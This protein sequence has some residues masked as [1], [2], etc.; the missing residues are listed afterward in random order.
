MVF[1]FFLKFLPSASSTLEFSTFEETLL[2]L[3]KNL[4][5]L[6]CDEFS[7]D[8]LASFRL[9]ILGACL[10]YSMQPSAFIF[11]WNSYIHPIL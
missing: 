1:L 11:I 4:E 7:S 10:V 6:V 8:I 2:P 3:G 9:D 5:L